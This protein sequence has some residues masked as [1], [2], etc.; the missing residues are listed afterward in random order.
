MNGIAQIIARVFN[1]PN[2][3]RHIFHPKHQLDKLGNPKEALEKITHAVLDK[4][5]TGGILP[6]SGSF[7]ITRQID[8]YI[9]E[10]RGAIINGELR[11]GTLF[12]L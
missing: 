7:I 5:Q 10:I 11:Y 2:K 9:V 1:D 12:I 3:V 4:T 6:E 8:G